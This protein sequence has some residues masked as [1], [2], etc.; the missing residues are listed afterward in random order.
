[1]KP[2]FSLE[3]TKNELYENFTQI[4][5]FYLLNDELRIDCSDRLDTYYEGNV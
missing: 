3:N 2:I 5:E 4:F 1:M